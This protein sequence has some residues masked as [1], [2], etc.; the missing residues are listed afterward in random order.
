MGNVVVVIDTEIPNPAPL[1]DTHKQSDTQ[2]RLSPAGYVVPGQMVRARLQ[3]GLDPEKLFL[4]EISIV[5]C[6]LPYARCF[7]Y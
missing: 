4:I 3:I 7:T 5:T 1:H 2:T 6:K